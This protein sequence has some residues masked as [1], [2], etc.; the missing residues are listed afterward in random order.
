MSH[1]I[2]D[3]GK[4]PLTGSERKAEAELFSYMSRALTN[5]VV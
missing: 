4:V 3:V 1:R 5:G 2:G